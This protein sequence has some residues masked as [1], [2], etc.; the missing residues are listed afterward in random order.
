VTPTAVARF[1]GAI[2]VVFIAITGALASG[3]SPLTV[4]FILYALVG[5]I[6]LHGRTDSRSRMLRFDEASSPP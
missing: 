6:D 2:A 3:F 4:P 1:V 5:A